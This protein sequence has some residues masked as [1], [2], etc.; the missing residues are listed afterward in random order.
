MI[1]NRLNW[2]LLKISIT[3]IIA[4]IGV[5][6][7]FQF[8]PCPTVYIFTEW[9]SKTYWMIV[10]IFNIN[11]LPP[12]NPYSCSMQY[13]QCYNWLRFAPVTPETVLRCFYV[14]DLLKS[15]FDEEAAV[16]VAKQ[17]IELVASICASSW[18]AV[19]ATELHPFK[20]LLVF[21]GIPGKTCSSSRRQ[22]TTPRWPN[23]GY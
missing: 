2:Y 10:K 23:V 6:S 13:K 21:P 20:E 3:S 1:I 5:F 22:S 9:S 12:K 7:L 15:L 4:M 11:S 8:G 17:L 18:Q 16:L 19:R 14:D